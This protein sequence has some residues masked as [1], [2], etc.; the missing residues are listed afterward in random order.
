[1]QQFSIKS[2]K[3]F[4]LL[5]KFIKHRC[6]A[7][8]IEAQAVLASRVVNSGQVLDELLLQLEIEVAP[9]PLKQADLARLAYLRYGKG[10]GHKAQLNYSDVMAYALAKDYGEPLAFVGN[11]FEQTDPK[12]IKFPI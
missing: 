2:G 3:A 9:L 10:Q 8:V 7:F 5:S 6:V 4:A 12:V 11:D 1:M